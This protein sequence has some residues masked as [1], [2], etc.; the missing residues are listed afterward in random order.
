MCQSYRLYPLHFPRFCCGKHPHRIVARGDAHT[1]PLAAVSL[2]IKSTLRSM[3]SYVITKMSIN[4]KS[5]SAFEDDRHL[6]MCTTM[7]HIFIFHDRKAVTTRYTH[8]HLSHYQHEHRLRLSSSQ[9]SSVSS[10]PSTRTGSTSHSL[11]GL[12]SSNEPHRALEQ[13]FLP[14]SL[15]TETYSQQDT[16]KGSSQI[17]S[18]TFHQSCNKQDQSL[19]LSHHS[20][21]TIV[22]YIIII[23]GNHNT[24]TIISFAVTSNRSSPLVRTVSH[25]QQWR[26]R[27]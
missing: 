4:P 8:H 18:T 12:F 7:S 23:T 19:R 5:M 21:P 20:S 6:K 10:S 22:I 1:A 16:V 26:H 25:H 17:T 14:V 13:I 15:S 2:S 9:P 24:V 3:L 11:T 27:K